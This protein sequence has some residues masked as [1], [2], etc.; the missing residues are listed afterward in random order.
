MIYKNLAFVHIPRTGGTSI[1]SSLGMKMGDDDKH[2][3]ALDIRKRIGEDNWGK[4]FVFSFV[5]NPWDRMVSLYYQPYFR[6]ET[7]FADKNLEYFIKNYHPADWEKK[8]FYEYLNTDGI[9][10]IGKYENRLEDLKKITQLTGI[11]LDPIVHERKTNRHLEY[12]IYYD[13]KTAQMVYD[14]YQQDIDKYGYEF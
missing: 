9:D 4:S 1:E 8:F 3:T 11:M 12:R 5:R 6:N 14:M 10:F 13:D 2:L 7:I